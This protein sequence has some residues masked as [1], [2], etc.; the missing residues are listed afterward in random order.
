MNKPYRLI[1]RYIALILVLLF[2]IESFAA[3][4]GDNDGAAFITK[5]EFDS[6]KNDFQSQLDRY[7]S[8]LDNKIDGAIASYLEGAKVSKEQTLDVMFSKAIDLTMRNYALKNTYGV[9]GS[10]ICFGWYGENS[11]VS[12]SEWD[13]YPLVESISLYAHCASTPSSVNIVGLITGDEEYFNDTNRNDFYWIGRT[14]T[15]E[16]NLVFTKLCYTT[17]PYSNEIGTNLTLHLYQPTR[18]DQINNGSYEKTQIENFWST[19]WSPTPKISWN[20]PSGNYTQTTP[21]LTNIGGNSH[22]TSS[23]NANSITNEYEFVWSNL[24]QDVVAPEFKNSFY[25]FDNKNITSKELLD[26]LQISNAGAAL[27]VGSQ[28]NSKH[29]IPSCYVDRIGVNQYADGNEGITWARVYMETHLGWDQCQAKLHDESQDASSSGRFALPVLG[30][31]GP[32]NTNHIFIKK[33]NLSYQ[34]NNKTWIKDATTMTQGYPLMYAT[35]GTTIT[36][37]PVFSDMIGSSA[38][39][40]NGEIKVVLS[41]GEFG[42][43]VTT[44]GGYVQ[45]DGTKGTGEYAFTTSGKTCKIKWTMQED[46]WIYVKWYPAARTSAN[47]S[48]NTT[49]NDKWSITL[50]GTKSNKVTCL[51][52]N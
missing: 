21:T 47:A 45:A 12:R 1:K 32:I 9:P 16:E 23:Y 41:Y 10:T 49:D 2:S 13:R 25:M 28:D 43:G 37:S 19:I 17:N 18:F 4:V 11:R 35:A 40:T 27:K 5:A 52:Q 3:V 46:G 29:A 20:Q 48:N 36:W 22:W 51:M 7:N 24:A 34:F 6:M 33:D 8:S 15:Y 42:D 31:L 14:N 38:V 44:A 39:T 50:D 30:G 26:G